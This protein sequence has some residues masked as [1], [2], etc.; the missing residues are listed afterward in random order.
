ML[1]YKR[2]LDLQYRVLGRV[3]NNCIAPIES[4]SSGIQI[5]STHSFLHLIVKHPYLLVRSSGFDTPTPV[6][7]AVIP[8]L[9]NGENLVMAASTGSGKTLAF[10]LPVIQT[11]ISQEY[12]VTQ[13]AH[14]ATVA[15]VAR[16][17]PRIILFLPPLTFIY[18]RI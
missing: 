14:F 3:L 6:Q 16:H 5:L 17:F 1:R 11:L 15:T 12:Q 13:I 7:K 4:T 18:H 2:I 10:T 8:R 9:L